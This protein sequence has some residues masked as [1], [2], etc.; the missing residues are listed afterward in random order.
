[1][2]KYKYGILGHKWGL[3]IYNIL[4]KKNKNCFLIEL[5]YKDQN[6]KKYLKNLRYI[7]NK[8]KDLSFSPI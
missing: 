1:M 6:I 3:K 4:K 2:R 7:I 5:N 8:G